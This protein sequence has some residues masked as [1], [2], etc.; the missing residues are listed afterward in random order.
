MRTY[1]HVTRAIIGDLRVVEPIPIN[2]LQ[3]RLGIRRQRLLRALSKLLRIGL[4]QVVAERGLARDG[5]H[6]VHRLY[7]LAREPACKHREA[8]SRSP[9]VSRR[10]AGCEGP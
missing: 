2:V 4:V 9:T 10:G 6:R 8:G 1:R 3:R 7:S 5:K